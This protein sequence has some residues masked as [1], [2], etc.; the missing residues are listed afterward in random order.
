MP[1]ASF[2]WA[3][4][5]SSFGSTGIG[6]LPSC[7]S[8]RQSPMFLSGVL[9]PLAGLARA[10]NGPIDSIVCVARGD[11]L[12]DTIPFAP[13][14]EIISVEEMNAKCRASSVRK[15]TNK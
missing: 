2:F 3:R 6:A 12:V 7:G 14:H 13:L 4:D 8:I 1:A 5:S 10:N 15:S 11:S 9:G